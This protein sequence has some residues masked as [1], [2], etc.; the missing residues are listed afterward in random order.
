MRGERRR[1]SLLTGLTIFLFAC[2]GDDTHRDLTGSGGES[3]AVPGAADAGAAPLYVLESTL[4]QPE[5]NQAFGFTAPTLDSGEVLDHDRSRELGTHATIYGREREGVFYVGNS[6]TPEITKFQVQPDGSFRELTKLSL[7]PFGLNSAQSSPDKVAFASD[8]KAYMV[9]DA[10]LQLVV[11]N[12]RDMTLTKT[13]SL[14]TRSDPSLHPSISSKIIIRDGRLY[15]GLSWARLP[16]RVLYAPT[17]QVVVLDMNTDTVVSRADVACS[18]TYAAQ[19]TASKTIYFGSHPVRGL[20]RR[21]FGAAEQGPPCVMRIPRG[22]DQPELLDIDMEALVGG[23]AAGQMVFVSDQLAYVRAWHD[24]VA[25]IARDTYKEN[26]AKAAWRWMRWEVGA[27]AATEIPGEP[28]VAARGFLFDIDG[29]LYGTDP[30]DDLQYTTL[31]EMS[32]AGLKR[33]LKI[34]GYPY[35]LLRVR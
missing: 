7:Q 8:T 24:E 32:E 29:K 28:L 16:D 13:I 4:I 26:Q 11:W 25:P 33:G 30:S 5:G 1:S 17:S 19:M 15:M 35:G 22:S 18:D 6:Q 2:G 10:G 3:G 20:A 21:A 14:G 9:D 31:V 27:P 12:P 23:R 34:R